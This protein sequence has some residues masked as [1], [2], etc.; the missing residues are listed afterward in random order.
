MNSSVH[1]PRNVE[2]V[3][4]FDFCGDRSHTGPTHGLGVGGASLD[5]A[6]EGEP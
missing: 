1:Y 5:A 6:F 3:C 2:G 4:L